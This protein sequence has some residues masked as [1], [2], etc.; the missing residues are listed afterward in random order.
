MSIWEDCKQYKA[1]PFYGFPVIPRIVE[2]FIEFEFPLGYEPNGSKT[3]EVSKNLTKMVGIKSKQ[4]MI[5]N[6]LV[7]VRI[8]EAKLAELIYEHYLETQ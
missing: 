5:S 4:A 6:N 3:G 1:F 7:R 8:D 2:G